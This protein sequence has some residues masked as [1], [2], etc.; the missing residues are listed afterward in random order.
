MAFKSSIAPLCRYCAKP[1][2]KLTRNVSLR[3]GAPQPSDNASAPF[4]RTVRV[5]ELPRSKAECQRLTNGHIVSVSYHRS[6]VYRPEDKDR[7]D[8]FTEWDGE[9]YRDEF[10]CKG[11]CAQSFGYAC[12]RHG[13]ATQRY[14]AAIR[15]ANAAA[16]EG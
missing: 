11:V 9:S 1:I 12:A 7:V 5:A 13:Q 6:E 3:T 16:A 8:G 14:N 15:A 2:P 10:F 4:S